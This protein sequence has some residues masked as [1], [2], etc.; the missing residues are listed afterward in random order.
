[1]SCS[2]GQHC[3]TTSD[4]RDDV[5]VLRRLRG[6]SHLEAA[7]RLAR[8]AGREREVRRAFDRAMRLK[9]REDIAAFD[10]CFELGLIRNPEAAVDMVAA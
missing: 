9:G 7:L 6:E 4:V 2:V 1:V 5:L 8:A 3:S 10:A